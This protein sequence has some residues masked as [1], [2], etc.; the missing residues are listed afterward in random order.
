MKTM[1]KPMLL[2][3]ATLAAAVCI[4]FCFTLFWVKSNHGL[5]WVQSRINAEI[6]GRITIETHR[7]SLLGPG[8][9]LY[10]IA[11]HDPKGLTLAGLSHLSVELDW[12][13]LW[14]REIRINRV[15]LQD[16]WTDLAVDEAAGINLIAALVPPARE[17]ETEA[18][19]P[20]GPGLPFNIV[21]ESIQLT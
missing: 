18:P 9:D 1:L 11:L 12:R 21:C 16:P 17:K 10:G 3:A 2:T 19:T 20:D 13:A 6:P 7:L 4:V 15:L 8:L 5:Q 14:R